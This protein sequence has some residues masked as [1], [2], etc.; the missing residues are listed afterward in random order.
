MNNLPDVLK[1]DIQK[2]KDN[3]TRFHSLILSDSANI[4]TLEIF[5]NNW[6]Y[7]TK[8]IDKSYFSTLKN[9]RYM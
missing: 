4:A 6:V 3:K 8:S 2:L 7:N 5:N 9:L 1:N